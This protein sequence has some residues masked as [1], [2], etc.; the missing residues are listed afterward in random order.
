MMLT[1]SEIINLDPKP[2]SIMYLGGTNFSYYEVCP[3]L[4]SIIKLMVTK[5]ENEKPVSP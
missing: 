3:F 2:F 4:L 5:L 1:I